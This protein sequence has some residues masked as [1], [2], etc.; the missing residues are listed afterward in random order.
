[1]KIKKTSKLINPNLLDCL[2]DDVTIKLIGSGSYLD[3]ITLDPESLGL[4]S[5]FP[6]DTTAHNFYKSCIDDDCIYI[7]T[8]LGQILALDKFSSEILATID[9]GM[10]IMSDLVQDDKNIYCICGVPLGRKREFMFNNFCVCI[11]DKETGEKKIQTSYFEGLPIGLIKDENYI[12]IIGG[13]YLVQYSCGG[14]YLR[15]THLESDFEYSPILGKDHIFCVSRDGLVKTLDKN[16]LELIA[17]QKAQPCISNP[18]LVDKGLVW[19]TPSGICRVIL[20]ENYQWM[21]N[22]TGMLPY[23][24]LSPDKTKLFTFDNTGHVISFDIN[25]KEA[26]ESIRI[27]EGILRNPVIVE[28]HLLVTSATQLHQLEVK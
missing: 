18:F 19:V 27:A 26:T 21:G 4:V 20:E 11:C 15:K 17:S 7:P 13:E 22:N 9:L 1:M 5:R 12:W 23:S 8:K 14:K 28:N 25:N 24:I 10:P 3:V 2:T 16:T 6:V